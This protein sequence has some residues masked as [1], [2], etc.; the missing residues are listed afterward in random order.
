MTWSI[1]AKDESTGAFGVLCA[2]RALAVGAVVPYGAGRTG[3]LATQALANPFYG[4]DGLRMLQEGCSSQDVVA[5]LSAVDDGREHRQIHVVDREGRPAVYT[6]AC[7]IDW[8]GGSV[9][10]HVSVAGNMLAGPQVVDETLRSYLEAESL[11]FDERLIV[12]MEAGDRAGGD[13]RGRQSC[14]I[15]IWTDAPFP[16]LDLRVDDHPEP[17]RELR[18]LWRLAHQGYVP[19][20]RALPSRARPAGSTDRDALYRACAEYAEVWN[21]SHPE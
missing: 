9:D 16:V 19:F 15:R 18:R 10:A 11:D 3:A 21:A 4:V 14:A 17:L 8:S 5:A 2:S 7:C 20:Q 1:V 6:G 13:R 12:A